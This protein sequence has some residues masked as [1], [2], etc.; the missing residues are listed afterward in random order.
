M[1]EAEWLACEDPEPMLQ[2][3]QATAGDRKLRLFAAACLRRVWSRIDDLGRAAVEAAELFA[4]GLLGTEELRAARLACRGAAENAAWYAAA[5]SALK[6]A[7]NAARSAQSGI[8]EKEG[9]AQAGLLRDVLGDPFRTVVSLPS[10]RTPS[11]HSLAQTMYEERDFARMGEL[12]GALEEAGCREED[13]LAH[14]RAG[15]PH[16]RGCWV[17]DLLLGKV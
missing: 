6:A 11:V 9:A 7:G 4:D 2:F 10:W 17:V 16:V 14:C 13:V 5:S 8:G 12:A 15:G 1:T 3:V